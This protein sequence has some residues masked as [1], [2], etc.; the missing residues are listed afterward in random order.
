MKNATIIVPVYKDWDSLKICI[1]SLKKNVDAR[2]KVLFVNDKGP[3]WHDMEGKIKKSIAGC[4]N[5]S[6]FVNKQNM[7]FVKTCNRAVYELD[8]TGNDILLLNSDTQVT[9]GFL[10]EML[11]VLYACEKHGVVC[12]RSNQ[13][14]ILTIPVKNNIGRA[15]EA[16]ASYSVFR[17]VS[18][19][20]PRFSVIPTGVGFAILIKRELVER[21]GLF[22]EAYSPGYNE[23]NDFCMRINQYGYSAVMANRAYVYH[24]ES[25]S[26]GAGKYEIDSRNHK[27]LIEKYP[28]Y[29][30][31]VDG[32]FKHSMHPA[33]YFADLAADHVYEKPRI[34]FSL[35]E[36]PSSY[37]GTAH[38]GLS[39]LKHFYR[40]FCEKYEIHILINDM[41]DQLFGVSRA[42]R[43]VWHPDH[44]EGTFHL[45]F[46]PSQIFHREHLWI[47]NRTSLRYVFC[48]QDIIS[49]RS[50]YLLTD[51]LERLE[52]FRKTIRYCAA[53]MSISQF[54]LDDTKGYFWNEFH[55]RKIKTKVIYHGMD[56]AKASVSCGTLPFQEYYM[57]F[58]NFYKH[59]FLDETIP[60]LKTLKQNFIILGSS[61]TGK[62][63]GNIYG[64]QSGCQ[65]QEWMN[66]L[67][68][69]AKAIIFPSVYEGFGLPIL[70]AVRFDKKIA[71]QNNGLNRELKREFADF[72]ENIYLFDHLETLKDFIADVEAYP[73]AVLK[74]GRKVIRTWDQAATELESF[75]AEVLAEKI[76]FR[77][78]EDRWSELKYAENICAMY[79]NQGGE[80]CVKA[81][82]VLKIKIYIYNNFPR[83][84]AVLKKIKMK[85]ERVAK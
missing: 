14:T 4:P 58:G 44:I 65:E 84:F 28:Y 45:A 17:Q 53:M 63:C 6:Y 29:D 57:V 72:S 81:G 32:Y 74:N 68:S 64:Y 78:L 33:E 80:H 35:Y 60:Y 41:A 48:M 34:L 55:R 40:L 82:R 19:L 39:I 9:D 54:S 1:N 7:G 37:N 83:L 36:I 52:I 11:E 49:L 46:S 71:V 5:F 18:P 31:A 66:M 2:H 21:F 16:E 73:K 42:Y 25:K 8:Q 61:E 51:D 75:L 76:D 27:M 77:L 70:D 47:L 12:P 24:F 15:L 59:K 79:R 50:S 43:N 30:A 38:Y 3:A 69:S 20:L 62:I 13:A 67:I 23:E 26:F 85:L 56:D 10:E 22:D